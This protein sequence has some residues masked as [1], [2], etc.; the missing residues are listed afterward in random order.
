MS[1]RA[2]QNRI[3]TEAIEVSVRVADLVKKVA[4]VDCAGQK[5]RRSL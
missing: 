4:K 1:M 2:V 3:E 5:C